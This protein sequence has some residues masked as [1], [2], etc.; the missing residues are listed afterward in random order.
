MSP[1][2]RLLI[3]EMI[4]GSPTDLI[5]AFNDLNMQVL[6][7]GKERTEE[8]L[9]ILLEKTDLKLSHVI[10]TKSPLRIIEATL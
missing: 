6:L 7:N 10:P 1:D 9:K 3:I 2:S 4:I 5:G 8:D